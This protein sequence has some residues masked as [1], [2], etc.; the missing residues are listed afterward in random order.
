MKPVDAILFLD[1]DRQSQQDEGTLFDE[2][3]RRLSR[4]P[5]LR[6]DWAQYQA[7][8]ALAW[9]CAPEPGERMIRQALQQARRERV[10]GQPARGAGNEDLARQILLGRTKESSGVPS[11]V[12]LLLLCASL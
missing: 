7:L 8:R 1:L 4:D 6:A 2:P 3:R 9:E 11:W 10:P 12:W 5:G